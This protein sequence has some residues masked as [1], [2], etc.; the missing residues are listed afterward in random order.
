MSIWAWASVSLYGQPPM[1]SA[2]LRSAR[3]R[4]ASVPGERRMPSCAKAQSWRSMAGAYSRLSAVSASRP[5]S[6]TMGSISTWL[7]M[8]VVPARTAWSRTRRARAPM[9]ST[10]KPRLASAVT[11]SASATVPSIEGARSERSAL[12]R[13]ICASTSPG[14]RTRPPQSTARCGRVACERADLGDLAVERAEVDE[15]A[16]GQAAG[17]QQE[18]EIR[19]HYVAHAV[20]CSRGRSPGPAALERAAGEA[21]AAERVGARGRAHREE[22]PGCV[23]RP[24]VGESGQESRARARRIARRGPRGE[25]RAPDRSS[26]SG[27]PRRAGRAWAAFVESHAGARRWIAA[28]APTTQSSPAGV[29]P[30]PK[31]I[32]R[33]GGVDERSGVACRDAPAE[34]PQRSRAGTA[35]EGPERPPA[36]ARYP[37]EKPSGP[38]GIS[39]AT[40]SAPR[41]SKSTLP[42]G[43]PG[44]TVPRGGRR[45][46]PTAKGAASGPGP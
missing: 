17:L 33:A 25:S 15:P 40:L 36:R 34:R 43:I 19:D 14:V 30:S 39:S 24:I 5:L 35:S 3:S 10:V 26:G 9:S 11:R 37:T 7:R 18:I 6:P 28:S 1:R 46:R 13:W 4:R 20:S 41:Q 21:D 32:E 8:A 44:A 16:V 45:S 22:P 27:P 31:P 2:P 23:L 12:S 38:C 29:R 42:T